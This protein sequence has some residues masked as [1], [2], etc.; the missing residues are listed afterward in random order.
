M[1]VGTRL[2]LCPPL[3]AEKVAIGIGEIQLLHAIRRDPGLLHL[4][5]HSQQVGVGPIYVGTSKV[6]YDV[7]VGTNTRGIGSRRALVL[8]VRC[9]QHE[10]RT[11]QPEQYPIELRRRLPVCADDFEAQSLA[12]E[13]D[14]G[15]HV[16]DRKQ[17]SY[18][19]NVN[20]H[21]ILR[22]AGEASLLT[23]SFMERGKPEN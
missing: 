5:P 8:I 18:A 21:L 11:I 17:R 7:L 10:F 9:V 12:V 20:R 13:L 14:R 23:I 16:E 1:S 3:E 2:P 22:V 15:L 4:Y 6:D 19:T